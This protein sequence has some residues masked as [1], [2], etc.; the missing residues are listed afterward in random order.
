MKLVSRPHP[1]P[2][3][4]FRFI[5]S[6]AKGVEDYIRRK[7]FGDAALVNLATGLA[8]YFELHFSQ[9]E[10]NNWDRFNRLH[11]TFLIHFING[12]IQS[13]PHMR[14]DKLYSNPEQGVQLSMWQNVFKIH[15]FMRRYLIL[16]ST[17]KFRGFFLQISQLQGS[18]RLSQ[19]VSPYRLETLVRVLLR[20]PSGPQAYEVSSGAVSLGGRMRANDARAL[21]SAEAQRGQRGAEDLPIGESCSYTCLWAACGVP[22]VLFS[23][24]YERSFSVWERT[25]QVLA[26]K[27]LTCLSCAAKLFTCSAYSSFA[28]TNHS[29][30]EAI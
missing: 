18:R 8:A 21:S 6:Y 25:L 23:F 28:I 29:Y 1:F 10:A 26:R 15:H 30:M 12:V 9:S 4:R 24:V 22:Y 27:T 19:N 14:T 20:K 3:K 13:L 11:F 7:G 16:H 17:K 2:S 5:C